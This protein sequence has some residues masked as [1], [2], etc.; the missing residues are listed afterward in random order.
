MLTFN[1][2]FMDLDGYRRP[3]GVATQSSSCAILALTPSPAEPP[4]DSHPARRAALHAI[5]S[6]MYH[7]LY[8]ARELPARLS[9]IN[10]C[11]VYRGGVLYKYHNQFH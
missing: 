1:N 5:R 10:P 3:F 11:I 6:V 4:I 8:A 9:F 7:L 2:N